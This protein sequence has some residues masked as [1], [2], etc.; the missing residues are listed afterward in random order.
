MIKYNDDGTVTLPASL[1]HQLQ[2]DSNWLEALEAAGVDN[3][4]GIE[5]A[6]EMMEVN[7]NECTLL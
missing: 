5:L 2:A 7:E 3:W 4:A 6:Y 1:Y